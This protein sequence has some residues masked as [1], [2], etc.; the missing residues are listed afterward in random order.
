M[1]LSFCR[2]ILVETSHPGN[3]GS[4]ARAMKTMG[5]SQLY[6]VNP[7][8]FPHPKAYELAAGADDVLDQAIVKTSLEEALGD[9]EIVF[10]T[11]AR[12]RGLSL[13]GF[14]PAECA[15]FVSERAVNTPVAF[16]FGREH[17]GLTNDELLKCHFHVNIPSNPEYSSLNLAQA[18]QIITYELRMKLLFPQ[19]QVKLKQGAYANAQEIEKFHQH[20]YEVMTEVHF[21]KTNRPTKR[22]LQRIRR[23]FNKTQLESTEI[24]IL[25]G[26]LRHIQKKIT[27]K[28]HE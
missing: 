18:V 13:E 24:S 5:F 14:S 25:R 20:L 6:L 7:K 15:T 4:T 16:V 27:Q 22:L 21:L 9:C 11:S 17:S 2:I 1:N 10:G 12:P 3:I 19:A 28:P 26:F 8:E 23:L